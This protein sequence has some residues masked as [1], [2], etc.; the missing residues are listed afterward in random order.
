M[1]P[2]ILLLPLALFTI[3]SAHASVDPTS[4]L[5]HFSIG[6]LTTFPDGQQWPRC[7]RLQKD[8]SF[9]AEAQK[10]EDDIAY[11]ASPESRFQLKVPDGILSYQN[12]IVGRGYSTA[13]G[14]KATLLTVSS[15]G[16]VASGNND[17]FYISVDHLVLKSS[18]ECLSNRFGTIEINN[19]KTQCIS[20][21]G[22]PIYN[23]TVIFDHVLP[24]IKE[25]QPH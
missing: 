3:Q 18:E 25:S 20:D 22:A 2:V 19:N 13:P 24:P 6:Q 1:S 7:Y 21:K 4:G 14:Y 16:Q 17:R 8:R 5:Y 9:A 11:C 15:A 12:K 23:L 10:K